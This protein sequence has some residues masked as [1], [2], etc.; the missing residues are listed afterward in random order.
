MCS[1]R[2]QRIEAFGRAIDELASRRAGAD[3]MAR[4]ADAAAAA[5]M[6]GRLAELWAELATLDP[7]IAKRLP[8]YED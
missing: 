2:E 5:E 8:T 7:E 6:L 1:T 4:A 3:G